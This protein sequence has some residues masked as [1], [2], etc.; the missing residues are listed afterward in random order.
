[1]SSGDM[2]VDTC[3]GMVMK[4]MPMCLY[5]LWDSPTVICICEGKFVHPHPEICDLFCAQVT[6]I[7]LGVHAN[8]VAKAL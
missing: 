3:L 2:A 4:V 6:V 5:S 1:M 7:V 8:H